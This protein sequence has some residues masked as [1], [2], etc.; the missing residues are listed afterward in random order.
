MNQD[1]N[2][3]SDLIRRRRSIKPASMDADRPVPTELLDTLFENATW[4]PTHGM[5]EPWHFTVFSG[6]S[7]QSLATEL[8]TLYQKHTPAAEIR[9]D[10]FAKLGKNPLLAPVVAAIG[11]TPGSNPKIPEVEEVEAVACA[12]QNIHLSATAAG[13]GAFWS[14]PPITALPE[15]AQFLGLPANGRCLGLLY[16]GWPAPGLPSPQSK[17]RPAAEKI[18]W[19]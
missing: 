16:L 8:Q 3:I 1:L 5:T 4:A 17:R 18:S 12:V 14:S 19:R 6:P 2:W 15:F 7:R 11:L 10:K 9:P 13:L